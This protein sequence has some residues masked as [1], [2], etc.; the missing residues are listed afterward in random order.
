MNAPELIC[1]RSEEHE[2]MVL[3]YMLT[4]RMV[5]PGIIPEYFDGENRALY[6]AMLHQFQTLG[7]IDPHQLPV[8]TTNA[9]HMALGTI[10]NTSRH[11]IAELHKHFQ[12]RSLGLLVNE[13][14]GQENPDKALRMAQSYAAQ[15]LL[16]NATNEYDHSTALGNL[17]QA[18]DDG[19]TNNNI[20]AGVSVGLPEFDQYID[21]L[22]A[23]KMYV[24]AA[25]KKTGKSRFMVHLAVEVAKK[26]KGVLL[27]SLEMNANRLNLL[28]L[29]NLSGINST[30]ITRAMPKADY[31]RL[32]QAAS[33]HSKHKW[34]IYND[35]DV[36]SIKARL[37]NERARHPIDVVFV[38]FIQR[39]R[40]DSVAHRNRSHE[41]EKISQDLADMAREENVAVVVLSQLTGSAEQIDK[42]KPFGDQPPMPD[43]S[44]CKESQAIPEN[45]DAIIILHNHHRHDSPFKQDGSYIVPTIRCKVEQRDGISGIEIRFRADLRTCRFS[46]ERT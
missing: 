37:V 1:S 9:A 19:I 26:G 3:S 41:V 39:L 24:V 34:L 13:S 12:W 22:E 32:S 29:S 15:A 8:A 6:N 20:I 30:Q 17:F 31:E 43:M 16:C 21:G 2:R 14:M 40:D 7:E 38:D 44:H 25:L 5:V 46:V 35:K 33:D 45:A 4:A 27:E 42:A 23:G 10:S 18:I 36:G 28:A 11:V